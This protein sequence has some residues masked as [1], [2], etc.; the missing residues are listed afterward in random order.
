MI[1]LLSAVPRLKGSTG[2]LS[3]LLPHV[4]MSGIIAAFL[5]GRPLWMPQETQGNCLLDC[6]YLRF[7]ASSQV[8]ARLTESNR[9]QAGQL[10]VC[11]RLMQPQ[12]GASSVEPQLL[13]QAE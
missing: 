11:L 10:L 1:A 4:K 12:A 8:R 7:A 6:S 5:M 13:P 9:P 3:R 2:V